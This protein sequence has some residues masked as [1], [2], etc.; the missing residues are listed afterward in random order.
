M[1]IIRHDEKMDFRRI[2]NYT[3]LYLSGK[4]FLYNFDYLHVIFLH[5]TNVTHNLTSALED[6]SVPDTLRLVVLIHVKLTISPTNVIPKYK[7]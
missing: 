5:F 6:T 1:R 7:M 4:S 2:V 3:S